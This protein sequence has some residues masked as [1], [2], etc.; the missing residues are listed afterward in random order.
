[1]VYK[2]KYSFLFTAALFLIS[3]TLFNSC[4]TKKSSFTHRFYHNT[5]AKYNGYFNGNE[6]L[7]EGVAELEK[8]HV[9]DYTKILPVY[10]LGTAENA[11]STN[12]FFEKAYIKASAVIK[13]HSIYLKKKEYVKWIPESYFLIGKSHFY[14]QDYTLA[15]EVFDFVVKQYPSFPTKYSAMLWLAKTYNLQKKYSK[16]ESMLD[17][18][19][20]KIDKSLVPKKTLREFPL[21]YADYHIRQENYDQAI[22]YLMQGID[23]NKKKSTRV[24]LTFI[25]AQIYQKNG[26]IAAA[27]K[28]YAKVIKLNPAYEM[29]FNAKINRAMCYDPKTD[30]INEI[31]KLLGKMAK[32]TKNKDY[33]DQIYYAMAELSLK[34][35]DTLSAIKY[36]KLSAEKSVSNNLQK[37]TSYFKLANLYYS[38][39]EYESAST[40]YDS[41]M[42]VLPKSY[43]DYSKISA[44]QVTLAKLVTNLKIVELEDSLQ[45]L[46]KL[47]QKEI[48][49]IIDG[50]ITE[51]IKEEQKKQEEL[52]EKQQNLYNSAVNTTTTST[53]ASWYFYNSTAINFGKT[54]FIKKWGS[55]KLEDLW[56]L[57]KK[58][59]LS[60]FG[61]NN[62]MTDST[63]S[64]SVKTVATTN[65]KDRN[66]YYK[67]IPFSAE[68]LKISN[69]NI[70]EA[71]YTIGLI[72]E[73]DLNDIDRSLE[74][75]E[76][77]ISRY[78]DNIYLVN[79]YYQL[80]LIYEGLG[81]SSKMEYYKNLVCSKDPK[82]DFCN[83]IKDPNFNKTSTANKNILETLYEE[84]Y[85]SFKARKWDSVYAKAG[86]A[87]TISSSD[88]AIIPKF[89]YLKAIAIGKTK[90]STTFIAALKQIIE[91]YPS[92][93]VTPM[94]QTLY[95]LYTGKVVAESKT[96]KD[97]ALTNTSEKGYTITDD[98]LHFYVIV[99]N[100]KN[101]KIN[102]LKNA[103]SDYNTANFP[104]LKLTISN[105]FLDN[106]RQIITVT[107]FENKAKALQYYKAIKTNQDIF[108]K[109]APA[110]YSQFVISVEN[111]P[112]MYKNKDV[113]NYLEFF[114]KNYLK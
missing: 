85:L 77:L 44:L 98:A 78:P 92:N 70:T 103:I 8:L 10:K 111:Y 97:T 109:Y 32:E 63:Q 84:T 17:L 16:S 22:E 112:N 3:A 29:A 54:E 11:T 64:D 12:S 76:K 7:K 15:S 59:M 58:Q 41:T 68:Q 114:N 39:P 45:N 96:A 106:N 20:N 46:A 93:R 105:I 27:S 26:N 5:T 56:R 18:L 9:D 50:I 49:S 1:L 89:L 81:N 35:P 102:T 90:D 25:L 65:L 21:V 67:N 82:G 79:T 34:K 75:F 107:H 33:L 99:A 62:D 47:P 57:S 38:M 40:Y 43:P 61:D 66:Y 91:K 110:D 94:A 88:T 48:Y 87:Y 28:L 37:A 69:A 101:I 71:L 4:S 6:S 80:Y 2:N 53:A 42:T 83:I 74:A 30:D 60:D 51:V 72:Y 23:K 52:L 73:N 100:I 14:K 95:D 108:S 36:Y 113:E 55:R 24:R 104:T 86:R 19:Q 31:T 13:R